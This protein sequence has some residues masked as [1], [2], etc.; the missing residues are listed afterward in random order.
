MG[1]VVTLAEIGFFFNWIVV[2]LLLLAH[3]RRYCLPIVL[4]KMLLLQI[5]RSVV[6][7]K[8]GSQWITITKLYC[9]LVSLLP[10][11]M[12]TLTKWTCECLC[13]TETLWVSVKQL[14]NRHTFIPIGRNMKQVFTAPTLTYT[15]LATRSL[16]R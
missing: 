5:R 12:I 15:P 14:S 2:V 6:V 4:W 13:S 7:S 9:L 11:L 3:L 1:F 16:S 10:N 8:Q